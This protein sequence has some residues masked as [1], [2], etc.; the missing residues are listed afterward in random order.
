LRRDALGIVQN[1]I[2]A[3]YAFDVNDGLLAAARLQ[4]VPVSDEVIEQAAA[5]VRRRLFGVLRDEGFEH[6]VVEAVLA[7]QGDNPALARRAV[8]DLSTT[9]AEPD[10]MDAFT[11]YARSK[12]IVRNLEESYALNP[13][14][15][16][17]DATRTLHST[18]EAV[19]PGVTDVA[20]LVQ[21]LR[22]LQPVIDTFFDE[23][24]VMAD[25]PDLRAARLALIQRIAALP[26]R[27]VDLSLLKGF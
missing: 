26:D 9:V 3:G 24:L 4:P 23:V 18:Y 25:D 10:W 17:E 15:Y 11:A 27:I 1:L 16:V 21:A 13:D 2:A 14:A 19:A 7:E 5:F 8:V 12:R 6:D 22:T 20:S